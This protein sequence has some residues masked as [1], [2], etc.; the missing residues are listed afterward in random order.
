MMSLNEYNCRYNDEN[1]QKSWEN[2]KKYWF[3]LW[4]DPVFFCYQNRK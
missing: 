4:R 3:T 1:N 2:E